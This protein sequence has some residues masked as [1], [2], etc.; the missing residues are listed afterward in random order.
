MSSVILQQRPIVTIAA[1]TAAAAI[2]IPAFYRYLTK[3][4]NSKLTY[5]AG[6]P[7]APM[8]FWSQTM[9]FFKKGTTELYIDLEKITD[10]AKDFW[11][12]LMLRKTLRISGMESLKFLMNK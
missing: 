3:N 11:C 9:T 5:V 6:F 7:V 8:S 10:G 2:L 1:V 4:A 12:F